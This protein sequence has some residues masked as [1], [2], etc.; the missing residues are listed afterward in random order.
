ML[1][2]PVT[3]TVYDDF[4]FHQPL[5]LDDVRIE[6]KIIKINRDKFAIRIVPGTVADPVAG[7][8]PALTFCLCAQISA[9]CPTRCARGFGQV[10]AISICPFQTPKV[11]AVAHTGAGYEKI[12]L[13]VL[14]RR[15]MLRTPQ[16]LPPQ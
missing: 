12:P 14:E 3:H 15:Q 13:A 10:A 7:R 6:V 1:I 9:P 4:H 8:N 2:W 11:S 5:S 16:A